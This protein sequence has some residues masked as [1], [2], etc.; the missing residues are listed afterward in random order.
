MLIEVLDRRPPLLGI[1]THRPE[2]QKGKVP[3]VLAHPALA[4]DH[5]ASTG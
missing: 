3:S 1:L 2:L 4:E 5:R